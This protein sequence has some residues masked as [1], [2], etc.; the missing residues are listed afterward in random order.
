[1]SRAD[2]FGV[3]KKDVEQMVNR[4]E[5]LKGAG[6]AAAAI[7]VGALGALGW[8]SW[9]EKR[10]AERRERW[11][12]DALDAFD[13]DDELAWARE[14]LLRL[15]RAIQETLTP[16]QFET[17]KEILRYQYEAV[18]EVGV[19]RTLP[20]KAQERFHNSVVSLYERISPTRPLWEL[21]SQESRQRLERLGQLLAVRD[22][23]ESSLGHTLKDQH[24]LTW[25]ELDRLIASRDQEDLQRA[26]K[27]ITDLIQSAGYR[28]EAAENPASVWA[29]HIREDLE[30]SGF[31]LQGREDET[32]LLKNLVREALGD[33]LFAL[34]LDKN[35][36]LDKLKE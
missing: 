27:V 11:A 16:Q 4:R 32:Y 12:Q 23:L 21:S 29:K 8:L 2:Q 22:T 3:T 34:N 26:Y 18:Y 31:S 13:P 15:E 7:G 25:D 10:N 17:C 24:G 19:T 28:A 30:S 5:F 35:R 14:A 1:M 33:I 20:P 36:I 9:E 6:A